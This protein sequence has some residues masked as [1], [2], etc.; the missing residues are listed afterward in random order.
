MFIGSLVDRG[1]PHAV[2]FL[3]VSEYMYRGLNLHGILEV[4]GYMYPDIMLRS[5][6]MNKMESFSVKFELIMSL[7]QVELR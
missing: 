5:S 6:T 2:M 7:D 4:S 3:L 1:P